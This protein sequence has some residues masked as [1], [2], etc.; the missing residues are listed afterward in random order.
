MGTFHDK[1]VG[2]FSEE[3]SPG[4]LY[5]VRVSAKCLSVAQL[6]HSVTVCRISCCLELGGPP[7]VAFKVVPPRGVLS[8]GSG[9]GCHLLGLGDCLGS[10]V[11]GTT[12]VG[13]S[14][15]GEALCNRTNGG[16]G[17]VCPIQNMVGSSQSALVLWWAGI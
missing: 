7:R 15:T 6:E 10:G 2:M 9:E 17:G 13:C 8:T 4:L 3:F 14:S 12:E 11:G 1:V 5:Q 16:D